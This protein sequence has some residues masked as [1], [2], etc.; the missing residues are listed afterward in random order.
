MVCT[1]EFNAVRPADLNV[2]VWVDH[3]ASESTKILRDTANILMLLELL[4]VKAT[5]V[6]CSE[7]AGAEGKTHN[8]EMP[9]LYRVSHSDRCGNCGLCD[10]AK[11]FEF[12]SAEAVHS[13]SANLRHKWGFKD[14][15]CPG[16]FCIVTYRH[17]LTGRS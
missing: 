11:I 17:C 9:L 12:R 4:W 3:I 6:F 13:L 10:T 5:L 16:Q 14:S 7:Q 8:P 1:P 15:E 2:F